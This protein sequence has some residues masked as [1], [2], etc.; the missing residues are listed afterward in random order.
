MQPINHQKRYQK[1]AQQ[2][3]I[4]YEKANPFQLSMQARGSIQAIPRDDLTYG[5]FDIPVLLELLEKINPQKKQTFYDLGNGSGKAL[6]ATALYFPHLILKGIEI[7]SPLHQLAQEK[8]QEIK[9]KQPK[10]QQVDIEFVCD[11]FHNQDIHDA[12]I[13]LVNATAFSQESWQQAIAKLRELKKGCYI[14][15]TSKSL[16]ASDYKTFFE[17]T[18]QMSWG[19]T[20]TRIYKKITNFSK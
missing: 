15:I 4:L 12:D 9:S 5:E 11:N 8:W 14:I 1:I 7:V 19:F 20:T 13:I 10:L 3:N 17:G 6:I 2:I 18:L 16:P